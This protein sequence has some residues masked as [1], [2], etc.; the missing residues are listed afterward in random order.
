MTPDTYHVWGLHVIQKATHSNVNYFHSQAKDSSSDR[1]SRPNSHHA[2]ID[3]PASVTSHYESTIR[4]ML[5][6]GSEFYMYPPNI[7]VLSPSQ[8][9][10]FAGFPVHGSA[11]DYGMLPLHMYPG[12]GA[13]T[14]AETR[15]NGAKFAEGFE[16]WYAPYRMQ[17]NGH[18][19]AAMSYLHNRDM[20]QRNHEALVKGAGGLLTDPLTGLPCGYLPQHHNHSHQHTHFHIHPHEQH[21]RALQAKNLSTYDMY[22]QH[23]GLWRNHPLLWQPQELMHAHGGGSQHRGLMSAED[24]ASG[25]MHGLGSTLLDRQLQKQLLMNQQSKYHQQVLQDE[26]LRQ[27]RHQQDLE[28]KQRMEEAKLGDS[29][30]SSLFRKESRS[31]Q[32]PSQLENVVKKSLDSSGTYSSPQKKHPVTI[33]LS[34]E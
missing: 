13:G 32:S 10:S 19:L 34:D 24:H 17:N 23:P 11:I 2:P 14:G 29:Y 26:Y 1:L 33:D 12:S 8:G 4:N 22:Q 28:M 15:E 20:E 18:H 30:M 9:L 27:F 21:L 16:Q 6:S 7:P 5:S 25:H 3:T 31:L